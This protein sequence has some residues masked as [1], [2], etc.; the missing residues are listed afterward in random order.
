MSSAVNM[1]CVKLSLCCGIFGFNTMGPEC[2]SDTYL[3]SVCVT[4]WVCHMLLAIYIFAVLSLSLSV[5]LF[6]S[7]TQSLFLSLS[8]PL[9]KP[10]FR[11]ASVLLPMHNVS[12]DWHSTATS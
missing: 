11:S 3:K 12:L 1:F 2:Q 7:L 9:H 6:H 5:S 4:V 10:L 8:L